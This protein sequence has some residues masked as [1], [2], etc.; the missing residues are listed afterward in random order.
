M[1]IAQFTNSLEVDD[2]WILSFMYYDTNAKLHRLDSYSDVRPNAY[3]KLLSN[4]D[5]ENKTSFRLQ[6]IME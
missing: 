5:Q 2:I 1:I 4:I 3:N 6:F